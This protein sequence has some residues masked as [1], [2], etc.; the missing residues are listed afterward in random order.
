MA[1]NYD[2]KTIGRFPP[3]IKSTPYGEPNLLPQ[4]PLGYMMNGAGEITPIAVKSGFIGGWGSTEYSGSITSPYSSVP[5][6]ANPVGYAYANTVSV[7]VAR[8]IEIRESAVARIPRQVI[9][10]KTGEANYNHPY[11]IAIRRARQQGQNIYALW[12][13]SKCVFGEVFLWPLVNEF[14]YKSD[15]KWLN[16]LG[17]NVQQGAGFIYSYSYSPITGGLP[18]TFA[19]EDIAHFMIPNWFNDLRGQSPLDTILLE[20]GIDKDVSR[21]TKAYFA[22]D[23]RPGV[24][25]IPETDLSPESAQQFMDYWKANLQGPANAGRPIMMPHM[26]KDIKEMQNAPSRDDV[27]IRE[28][29]RR[30]ICAR[31]GVPLSVAGAWDDANYQSAPE[32]RR[33]LYEE[34]IFPECNE[35]DLWATEA[36]LPYF[37]DSGDY[38]V[39][40]DFTDVKALVEDEN[41]K[42]N[43]SNQR[44]LA[45]GITRN[46]YRNEAGHPP[47]PGEDVLYV[48][49]GINV[50]PVSQAGQ[51]FTQPVPG[52]I[53]VGQAPQQ[54]TP[55]AAPKVNNGAL[56]VP[57][58]PSV[59]APTNGGNGSVAPATTAP[60]AKAETTTVEVEPIKIEPVIATIPQPSALDEL[61]AWKKKAMNGGAQKASAFVC[62]SLPKDT[63][64]LVRSGLRFDMDKT[65]LKT[66]FDGVTDTLKKNDNPLVAD[67]EPDYYATPEEYLA[68]WG[69][70]DKLMERLGNEWLTDYMQPAFE[71][72]ANHLGSGEAVDRLNHALESLHNAL[73][74]K[75]LGTN[76]KPGVVTEII[77]AGMGAANQSLLKDKPANPEKAIKADIT[78]NVDW[79]LLAKEA[80]EFAQ[81]YTYKLIKNLDADTLK[82]VQ[83]TV[84]EWVANGGSVADLRKLLEPLFDDPK[85]AAV[86]AATESTRIFNEGAQKRWAN[87][88]A[89]Q[90]KWLTVR[91]ARVCPS[92]K[93]LYGAIGTVGVGW[94]LNGEIVNIPLHPNCRCFPRV[95]VDEAT[96]A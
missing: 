48:P 71:A 92:C 28:S 89:T 16:N 36:L 29:M 31:F 51:A 54:Q 69:E 61:T 55:Q 76:E 35:L 1:E 22:N 60:A 6:Q 50:V 82:Q 41:I 21:Y 65:A 56:P 95:I 57:K 44:L 72:V 38:I 40:S 20:I 77:L 5:I 14:G 79:N 96:F 66:L 75:W 11:A 13:R 91:D 90:M 24:F 68:Y 30:E 67:L 2:G 53:P 62:Y 49:A 10:K 93:E 8:C 15:L 7:W 43:V 18:L 58:A 17:M 73:M 47:L 25:L 87:V 4:A 19:A 46:E 81:I 32:Q 26:I 85:R 9:N 86:I 74:A 59:G 39:K 78:L 3:R 83:K 94:E 42:S 33:S 37:D 70:Y 34:T 80:H 64:S 45:G 12:E 52:M 27:E 88:G 23:A 84:S 63:E